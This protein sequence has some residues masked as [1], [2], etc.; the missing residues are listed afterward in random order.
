MLIVILLF[1]ISLGA[2]NKL[3]NEMSGDEILEM[4]DAK[5]NEFIRDD[6]ELENMLNL[7]TELLLEQVKLIIIT[8]SFFD[9]ANDFI[10]EKEEIKKFC[11]LFF[12]EV[13]VTNDQSQILKIKNT[14][15]KNNNHVTINIQYYDGSVFSI[16]V[17]ETGMILCKKDTI[18]YSSIDNSVID[19]ELLK[20]KRI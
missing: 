18:Y 1:G 7:E 17:D 11:S 15:F 3:I 12:S 14:L 5:T 19:V 8:R 6:I 2:C 13:I 4:N 16:F 9:C 10:S 20:L